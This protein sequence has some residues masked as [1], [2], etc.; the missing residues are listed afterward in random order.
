MK[1]LKLL[2]LSLLFVAGQQ[3]IA[4]N[5]IV[6]NNNPTTGFNIVF[7]FGGC[8]G[9]VFTNTPPLSSTATPYPA[10][11]PLV[12]LKVSFTDITCSTPQ[13]V[14]IGIPFTT[15]PTYYRYVLC[16]GTIINFR[17]YF[18]GIDYIVDII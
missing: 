8:G 4:Q 15:N 5:V 16:N 3:A 6:N 14:N 11:C 9:P 10:P 13:P 2:V 7:D 18:N 1:A 17:V 12:L